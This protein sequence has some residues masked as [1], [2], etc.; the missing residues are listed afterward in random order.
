M[1]RRTQISLDN[2]EC[3]KI[4]AKDYRYG[5][6]EHYPSCIDV[7]LC[8]RSFKFRIDNSQKT[9]T[10]W[11]C[12]GGSSEDHQCSIELIVGKESAAIPWKQKAGDC[13]SYN[14]QNDDR[15]PVL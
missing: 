14:H 2:A 10:S 9:E 1:G 3:R 4:D 11:K 15:Q 6:W 5:K 12:T 13:D 8:H 7:I